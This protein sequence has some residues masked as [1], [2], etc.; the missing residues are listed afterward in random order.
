MEQANQLA[1][2]FKEAFL[3]GKWIA[4]TNYKEILS[5]V[6]FDEAEQRIGNLNTIALLTFHIDYYVAGLNQVFEGGTLDIR[7]Q[8][9]FDMKPLENEDDWIQLVGRF[10]ANAETFFRHVNQLSEEQLEDA[11]VDPKY[12]TYRRNIEAMI[13]HAYY[14]LG[15]ISLIKKMIRS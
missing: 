15:Q 9:S 7:D 12:G 2:R 13:E 8:F 10:N 5:D 11:F 14:H 1:T 3:D 6:T 4:N